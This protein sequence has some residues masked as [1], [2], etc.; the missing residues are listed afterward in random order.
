MVEVA[1]SSLHVYINYDKHKNYIR[2]IRKQNI[3]LYS[4]ISGTFSGTCEQ[5]KSFCSRGFVVAQSCARTKNMV[6]ALLR[7]VKIPCQ[8]NIYH[9]NG[10]TLEIRMDP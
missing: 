3:S 5:T 2:I 7:T 8:P 4:D 10:K 1:V 9:E 6:P